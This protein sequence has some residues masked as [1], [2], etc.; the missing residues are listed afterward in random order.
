VVAALAVATA[1][2]ASPGPDEVATVASAA[3]TEPEAEQGTGWSVTL[4][5]QGYLVPEDEDYLAVIAA[6][7][8]GRWHLEAR[9]A[10]EALDTGSVFAGLRFAAGEEPSLEVTPMLGVVFGATDGVAPAYNLTFAY[11][12]LEIYSEGE[13]LFDSNGRE[14]SFF[15]NWSEISLSPVEWLRFG[16]VAQRTRAYE[17]GLEVQRGLLAG[18][19]WRR[20]SLTTYVF[21]LGWEDATV[22]I[23]PSLS[24]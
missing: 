16:L 21:N 15:Y 18:V 24:F 14:E 13:Y 20:V 22:V 1:A 5:G 10:Y 2:A 6:A 4:S 23:A 19:T 11:R 7:D 17:T 12:R 9:Y 3:A 8:R